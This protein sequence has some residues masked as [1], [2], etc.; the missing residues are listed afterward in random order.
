[1]TAIPLT[2]HAI[3]CMKRTIAN[4]MPEYRSAHLSEAIASG[5]GYRT[6]A[7]LLP[8]LDLRADNDPDYA[9][10]SEDEFVSR[11]QAL[12]GI[13]TEALGVLSSD[14]T[15]FGAINTYSTGAE[16]VDLSSSTRKRAWRNV[17][18][19]GI[20]AGIEQR[21][22]SIRPA[23]CRWPG[24]TVENGYHTG[25]S[26]EFSV[27]GIPA[28]GWVGDIGHDELS[29]HVALWPTERGREIIAAA[30]A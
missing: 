13:K 7:A 23:D 25:T 2:S 11:L 17:M 1:M 10:W 16:R 5:L 14:F 19:A 27:A 29:I 30:N 24:W 15:G 9:F 21:L 18:V 12:S 20:N 3:K 4:M 6:H 28:L 22:F 8:A 26:F